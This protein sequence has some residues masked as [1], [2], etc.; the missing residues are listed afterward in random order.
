MLDIFNENDPWEI[1]WERHTAY[2]K[3]DSKALIGYFELN[4]W[5]S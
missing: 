5:I 3:I 4:R 1:W 2:W